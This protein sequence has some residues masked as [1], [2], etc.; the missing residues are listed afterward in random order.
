MLTFRVQEGE[1]NK[2]THTHI[3]TLK[4]KYKYTHTHL[5]APYGVLNVRQ[6]MKSV[7]IVFVAMMD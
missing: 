7:I 3:H 5:H 2:R 6:S 1:T 4:H